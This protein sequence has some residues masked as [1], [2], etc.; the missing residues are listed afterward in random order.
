[1]ELGARRDS[2]SLPAVVRERLFAMSAPA[3]G[4]STREIV[5]ADPD[6][7]Y[8]VELARVS[9]GN[10][11]DLPTQ[12]RDVLRQRIAGET[13]GTLQQQFESSLRERAEIVVY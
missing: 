2:R 7:T 10:P 12:E 5:D 8:L 11:D 1:V 13:G 6:A 4:G 9:S 3:E